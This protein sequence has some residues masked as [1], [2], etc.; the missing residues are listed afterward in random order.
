VKPRTGT[1]AALDIGTTKLCC[2]IARTDTHGE[3]RVIGIGHQIAHGLRNGSIIDMEAAEASILSAVSTAEQMA[4]ETIDHIVVNLSGGRQT[5][6]NTS[7]DVSISGHEITDSDL[8]LAFQ[9]G[10]ENIGTGDREILHAAPVNYSIDG[11]PPIRDPRG[12]VGERLRV[13][14]HIITAD[15][16]AVRNLANCISRCH[17]KIEEIVPSP[18]AAGLACLVEDEIDLGVTCID[19]GG[20]TTSLSVYYDGNLVRTDSIPIGGAHVTGDIARGLSTTLAHAER[21]KTLYGN[22]LPSE[23]DSNES[24]DVPLIGETSHNEA[25]HVPKSLL[26]GILRPR[27]EEILE[28]IRDRLE[29]SGFDKIAGQ[30]VVLTGGASQ[31]Q[32]ICE[33]AATILDKH[34]RLGKPIRTIGIA[35][36]TGGPAFSV[37]AGLLAHAVRSRAESRVKG[38]GLLEEPGGFIGRLGFWLRECF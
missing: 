32:G 36:A 13:N 22:A 5:S 21:L 29:A 15:L 14:M 12:M 34:V 7:I 2:F 38:R 9:K 11:S 4:G 1:I 3:T 24:I 26:I 35:E 18:Y 28:M 6:H 16:G 27:L 37:C 17:L 30:R 8:R 31:M 20:G 10:T 19:M 23:S 25:N 33:L